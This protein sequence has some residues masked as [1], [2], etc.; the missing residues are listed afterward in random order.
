MF[1]RCNYP[2][3]ILTTLDGISFLESLVKSTSGH[4]IKQGLFEPNCTPLYPNA[5]CLSI[6]R[7]HG[8]QRCFKLWTLSLNR[9]CLS[10]ESDLYTCTSS[11]LWVRMMKI[12][13]DK[14]SQG[15][16]V[17]RL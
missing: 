1:G 12:H 11:L 17:G 9:P 14:N 2:I 6:L 16:Q 10:N 3:G 8:Y 15:A 7:R 4:D 5:L 13:I